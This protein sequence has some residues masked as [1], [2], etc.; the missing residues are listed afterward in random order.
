MLVEVDMPYIFMLD[1][2]NKN[3]TYTTFDTWA[4]IIKIK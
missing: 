4:K 2:E 1:V 3:N